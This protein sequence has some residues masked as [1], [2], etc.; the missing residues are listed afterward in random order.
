MT[1]NARIAIPA[2]HSVG[3]L[4]VLQKASMKKSG[5]ECPL[6]GPVCGLEPHRVE[7]LVGE[8]AGDQGKEEG[9]GPAVPCVNEYPDEEDQPDDQQGMTEDPAGPEYVRE[10]EEPHRLVNQVREDASERTGR[11]EAGVP[12]EDGKEDPKQDAGKQV[13]EEVH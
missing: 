5:R 6:N 3:F 1:K 13:G 7:D 10:E 11:D 8:D 9:A 2:S 12:G 4:I